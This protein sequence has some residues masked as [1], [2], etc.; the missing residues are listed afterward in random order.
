[1]G[2]D[3]STAGSP[4]R[5][6]WIDLARGL[7]IILVIFAHSPTWEP[8]KTW[9]Y[10]F[11]V[12]LFFFL[13]GLLYNNSKYLTT[14]A[15]LVARSRTL[16]LPY[17][18]LSGVGLLVYLAAIWIP[19][20]PDLHDTTPLRAILGTFLGL[21]G[22]S[23]WNGTLWFVTCL[24]SLEVLYTALNIAFR[25]SRWPLL[26]STVAISGGGILV[27]PIFEVGVVPWNLEVAAVMLVFYG[28][29]NFGRGRQERPGSNTLVALRIGLLALGTIACAHLNDRV[30]AYHLQW[31]NPVMYFVGSF[32]G[33]LLVREVC[34]I[35]PIWNPLVFIGRTS[36]LFLAFHQYIVF[37]LV[38]LVL[39]H[40][41]VD[42]YSTPARL[43]LYGAVHVGASAM[44]L[45]PLAVLVERHAPWFLGRR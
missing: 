34:R 22:T 2:S 15:F 9:V 33:I 36:L 14:R 11:H 16:L 45:G 10:T 31:G 19:S 30:D 5:I 38:R 21:R 25:G 1:M 27:S 12:P 17:I 32:A 42:L 7:G 3:A 29:G 28:V 18:L 41:E 35:C 13:S 6:A 44:I 20:S 4:N 23:P 8:A 37:F 24:F 26:L 43:L 39:E 40:L